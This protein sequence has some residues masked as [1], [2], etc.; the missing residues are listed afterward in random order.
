VKKWARTQLLHHDAPFVATGSDKLSLR[1]DVHAVGR[2][3]QHIKAPHGLPA[4]IHH[5]HGA[6]IFGE[7]KQLLSGVHRPRPRQLLPP[8][9]PPCL[10]LAQP[11]AAPHAVHD[12][13]TQTHV[14]EPRRAAAVTTV[15]F[16][17]TLGGRGHTAPAITASC[18][19]LSTAIAIRYLA[20]S[21]S[22]Q[23]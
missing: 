10:V 12:I 2:H 1:L 5:V 3:R 11:A 7:G 15:A 14:L 16:A 19:L 18:R 4:Q 13:P 21:Q 20:T 22:D 23:R 8:A 6:A 9:D 17:V